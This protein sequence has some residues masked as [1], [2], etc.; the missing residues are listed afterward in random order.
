MMESKIII[1]INPEHVEN[2]FN[3]TKKYEYRKQNPSKK[4]T[5][6]LIYET[7]PKK[8]IV[9]EVEILDIHIGTPND[10]WEL[11]K[12]YS[13]INKIFFYKYF[14]NKETSYAYKLGKVKKYKVPK[15]L[16]EFGISHP[17][18]SFIYI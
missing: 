11:T 14:K 7:N 16:K 1:S 8:K 18:Q 12:E 6:M 5:K 13:G 15:E 10:I 2:I 4:I 17:P 9:W 3:G